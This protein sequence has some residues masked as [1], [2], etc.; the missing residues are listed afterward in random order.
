M[1]TRTISAASSGT[2]TAAVAK[3]RRHRAVSDEVNTRWLHLHHAFKNLLSVRPSGRQRPNL[4]FFEPLCPLG[5]PALF[6]ELLCSFTFDSSSS[7]TF[8]S[9]EC[10]TAYPDSPVN[11]FFK[12]CPWV[13]VQLLLSFWTCLGPCTIL[14]M[15]GPKS[16]FSSSNFNPLPARLWFPSRDPRLSWRT[17]GLLMWAAIHR[18]CTHGILQRSQASAVLSSSA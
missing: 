1:C 16:L 6:M 17:S 2:S 14:C 7:T 5:A 10:R 3:L 18:L 15:V 4:I 11:T 9:M 13:M 8:S 12:K